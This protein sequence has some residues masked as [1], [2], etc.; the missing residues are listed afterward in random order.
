[1]RPKDPLLL[2]AVSFAA[3]IVI[4]P[5]LPAATGHLGVALAVVG[6][7]AAISRYRRWY[8]L[9]VC[10]VAGMLVARLQDPGKAPELD[11]ATGEVVTLA[12]CVT[13]PP[14][15]S[16]G[17]EQFV[18]D[19]EPGARARVTKYLRDDEPPPNLHY[20]QTIEIQ[21]KVRLPRNFGNPGA[22]DYA[23]YLAH[24]RIYW[25][26]TMT[27]G[28]EPRVLP[29]ACGSRAMAWLYTLR[30]TLLTRI[31]EAYQGKPF[32]IAMLQALLI[33]E[34]ARFERVWADQFRRTGTYHAIVISGLH[35][36][37]I[38]AVVLT[39]LGL[40][41]FDRNVMRLIAAVLV[42]MY[43]A[44]C[45][46]Q[47]PVV[48]AA[49]GFTLHAI[50]CFYYRKSRLLNLLA[51][52]TFLF[53]AIDTVQI[54]EASFQLTFLSV[55]AL[56][57]LAAPAVE[58]TT[59]PLRYGLRD[60]DDVEKDIHV[61]PRIAQFRVEMR[62]IV[63]TLALWLKLP[64]TAGMWLVRFTLLPLFFIWETILI[65]AVMQLGL[66]L[67][68]VIYF[69]RLSLSGL[70]A[71]VIVTPLLTIAVPVAL[72]ALITGWTWLLNLTAWMV[73]GSL[74]IA[75][76]HAS[77]EPNWR[78]PDPPWWL[79][80]AFLASLVVLA[81]QRR[82]LFLIPALVLLGIIVWH[83]FPPAG[84]Q[85]ELELTMIDVG[86][87]DSLLIG[88]PDG[89]WMLM[90]GGGIPVF[91]NRP[92]PKM[93]I[94]QDVVSSYLFTR[95]IRR[96]DIVAS[97]HQHEDHAG[98]LPAI[99][100]NFHPS[101]LWAG[102]SPESP[103]WTTLRERVGTVRNLRRGDAFDFGSVHI[104]VLAPS[105]D[106]QPKQMPSNNDSLVLRMRYGEHSFLLTGDTEGVVEEAMISG[107]G[108]THVIKV[109]HHGSK[110]STND[111]FVDTVQPLFAL[112]SAGKDN[113]FRHPHPDVVR[114]LEERH[115]SVFRSDEWGL[116]TIRSNGR[117]FQVETNRGNLTRS[118]PPASGH[119]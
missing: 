88:F 75:A 73:E 105:V 70:S 83:P 95:G 82:R 20:G 84:T 52:L 114:R 16:E 71:N 35:V 92:K 115:A 31:E 91:G 23:G 81:V 86:Q 32:N 116:V 57:A 36:T 99:I 14:S 19:L 103:I 26:A 3:G 38:A 108:K 9:G 74:R 96:I 54:D 27:T 13:E 7:A 28:S 64:P 41:P 104:D 69:H 33:G 43:A 4:A 5:H 17:K 47:A 106:Y 29:G 18:L 1:V 101:E 68:M 49:G 109:A 72:A 66:A 12:G 56:G 93:D 85:G 67:P 55:L 22:F 30:T 98:G 25:T 107:L 48:R 63:E 11:A 37:V 34:S 8:M 39:L 77:W 58:A 119:W 89:R 117:R 21:A 100:D 80:V 45:G 97:S 40:L 15:L 42:W 110:T 6:V 112:I 53:L 51:A 46:W 10:L 79:A 94:G 76:W 50:G 90:D 113:I 61:P 59:A 78:I 2:A 24:R 87:G 62:L 65:S 44:M 102:A 60:L 118:L 111:A